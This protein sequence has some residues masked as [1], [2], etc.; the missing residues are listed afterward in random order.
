MTAVFFCFFNS[1]QWISTVFSVQQPV[2]CL[3]RQLQTVSRRIHDDPADADE[4]RKPRRSIEWSFVLQLWAL[5]GPNT[6]THTHLILCID[7][8]MHIYIWSRDQGSPSPQCYRPSKPW[9]PA[10][11]PILY[12]TTL[13]HTIPYHPIPYHTIPYYTIQYNTILYYT[14]LYCTILY[15]TTIYC[16]VRYKYNAPSTTTGGLGATPCTMTWS[17]GWPPLDHIYI[18]ASS[19]GRFFC[20]TGIPRTKVARSQIFRPRRFFSPE[21]LTLCS[22]NTIAQRHVKSGFR[23]FPPA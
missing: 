3:S 17:G 15:Y 8:S 1:S 10:Q 9:P 6:C 4:H 14:I 19:A 11:R 5:K 22:R 12:Y 23:F 7:T 18:P 20:A 13:Y 16:T 21:G 2:L